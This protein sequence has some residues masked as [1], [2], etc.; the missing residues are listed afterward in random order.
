MLQSAD[1]GFLRTHT[2]GQLL[3]TQAGAGAHG[4]ELVNQL[5]FRGEPVVFIFYLFIF[6]R[7]VLY[8][9]QV[10]GVILNDNFRAR[11]ELFR[12]LFAI[13]EP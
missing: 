8:I 10:H 9:V 5:V 1:V 11:N 2:L 3:L 13:L 6:K 12:F 4:K 7:S